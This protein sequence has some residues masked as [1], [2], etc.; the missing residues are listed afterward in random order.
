MRCYACHQLNSATARFCVECGAAFAPAAFA[1]TSSA[2]STYSPM[3]YAPAQPAPGEPAYAPAPYAAAPLMPAGYNI[4]APYAMAP[5][6]QTVPYVQAGY[7]AAPV[8]GAPPSMVNNVTVTHA[9]VASALVAAPAPAA[10]APAARHINGAAALLA[11]L[12]FLASGVAVGV[13]WV[14]AAQSSN[15]AIALLFC[16]AVTIVV[17]LLDIFIIDR[18]GRG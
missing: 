11:G 1:Q 12:F 5:G 3:A 14:S 6:G 7:A 4:P 18:L 10:P 9:Q 16:L 2:D 15:N 8:P 17:L 13:L